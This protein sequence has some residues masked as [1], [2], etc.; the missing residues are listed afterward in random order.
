MPDDAV[1]CRKAA[2]LLSMATERKLR[3]DEQMALRHHLDRCIH[4]TD[5]EQQLRFI[6][7]AARLFGSRDA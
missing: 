4:C 5:Y 7:E 2:W 6:R 3:D 1:N